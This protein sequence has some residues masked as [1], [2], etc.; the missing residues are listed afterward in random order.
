MAVISLISNGAKKMFSI[1]QI[2]AIQRKEA[3][4]T[5]RSKTNFEAYVHELG[6]ATILGFLAILDGERKRIKN[7]QYSKK[8]EKIL[9]QVIDLFDELKV[10]EGIALLE[11]HKYQEYS[12]IFDIACEVISFKE[13][14][15]KK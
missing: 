9:L 7:G 6:K 14:E 11:K 8:E 15:N 3:P 4:L 2:I 13:L 12:L 5:E 1:S 10:E